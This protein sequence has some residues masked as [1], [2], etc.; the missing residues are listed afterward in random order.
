MA[1]AVHSLLTAPECSPVLVLGTLWPE[2]AARYTVLPLP[3]EEDPHSRVRELPAGHTAD[4]R[5]TFDAHALAGAAAPA[6]GGDQLLADALT[7]AGIDGRVTQDL[8]GARELLNRYR[9]AGA[10]RGPGRCRGSGPESRRLRLD[11]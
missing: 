2:Y 6:R 7:R 4:V 11:Q 3:G 9:D 8:A 5:D 10:G 1:A